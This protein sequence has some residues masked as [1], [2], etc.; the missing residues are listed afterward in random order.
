MK[1]KLNLPWPP[2]AAPGETESHYGYTFLVGEDGGLT[3]DI[4]D[5]LAPGEIAAGRMVAVTAEAKAT[6]AAKAEAAEAKE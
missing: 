6:K 5:E 2:V 3:A 4:P 1:V